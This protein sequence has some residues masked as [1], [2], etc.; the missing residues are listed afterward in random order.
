[1]VSLHTGS[2]PPD[3]VPKLLEMVQLRGERKED[4]MNSFSVEIDSHISVDPWMD[5]F[6]SMDV[7]AAR[8]LVVPGAGCFDQLPRG[9]SSGTW[10]ILEQ[11]NLHGSLSDENKI[12][13]EWSFSPPG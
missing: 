6:H 13:K 10:G 1:M 9:T 2:K 4:N 8:E 7:C 12:M 3:S 5:T 11:W